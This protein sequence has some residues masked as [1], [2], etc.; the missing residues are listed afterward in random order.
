MR[1]SFSI[2]LITP[3][4]FLLFAFA[5]ETYAAG[6]LGQLDEQ[7][8]RQTVDSLYG[9]P[10]RYGGRSREGFDCSGFVGTVFQDQGIELPRSSREMYRVGDPVKRNQLA[11]G[12]LV[13][14]RT[15][16][17]R[18]GISHVGIVNGPDSF[19]HANT[20]RGVITERLTDPYWK[21]RYVGARRVATPVSPP[22]AQ[23][24]AEDSYPFNT[25][26]LVN[27]PT[28]ALCPGKGL[29]ALSFATG[30]RGDVAI[31]P[32][33]TFMNRLQAGASVRLRRAVGAG[34]PSIAVP[35]IRAKLRINEQIGQIP[36]FAI[37]F[38]SGRDELTYSAAS[39]DST[40]SSPRRGLFAVGSGTLV[41]PRSFFLGRGTGH[42]GA[43]LSSFAGNGI[44]R[45]L[46]FFMGVDQQLLQRMTLLGE[47][48]N[49]MGVGGWRANV[50]ARFSIT[51][52][53]VLEY[54]VL[55]MAGDNIRPDKVL[56][57][58]FSVPY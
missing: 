38:D 1:D 53:A 49:I 43:S 5:T 33:F 22:P 20:R 27:T 28:I 46:S 26:S 36:G 6:T 55:H 48:D 45:N 51:D 34:T 52:D 10:Y 12:D 18:R 8:L 25:S 21:A 39:G 47:I 29:S 35:S 30:F 56:K 37:G 57:F 31:S 40:G 50:G 11:V 14:F 15:R 58:S 17:R 16:G 23:E 7:R 19:V 2:P 42:A 54:A 44:K 13:F 41:Y 3:F 9:S 4:C 32:E 24:I